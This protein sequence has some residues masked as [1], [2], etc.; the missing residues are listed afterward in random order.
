MQLVKLSLIP[1][2]NENDEVLEVAIDHNPDV[3]KASYVRVVR[4]KDG[5][6]RLTHYPSNISTTELQEAVNYASGIIDT[7]YDI[8]SGF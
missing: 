6:E 4:L 3:F 8:T 5:S 1:G 7:V 2:G